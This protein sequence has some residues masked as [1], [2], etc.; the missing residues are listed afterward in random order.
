MRRNESSEWEPA[1]MFALLDDRREVARSRHQGLVPVASWPVG[2]PRKGLGGVGA[3]T[4]A[5]QTA[6][7]LTN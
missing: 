1:F 5:M 4:V 2:D 3:W 6:T 7:K